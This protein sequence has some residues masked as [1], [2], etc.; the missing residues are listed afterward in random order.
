MNWR[1]IGACTLAFAS[2]QF[3]PALG[4]TDIQSQRVQ[5]AR[6]ASSATVKGTIKGYAIRDYVVGARAGQT[7]TVKL[8]TPNT[9]NYFNVTPAGSDTAIFVGSTS[10]NSF[11]GTLPVSGDYTIRVYLMR[12]A[13]RRNETANYALAIGVTG[14]PAAVAPKPSVDAV[15]PGTQ[16]HAVTSIPCKAAP[17]QPTRQCKAGVIRSPGGEA[18]VRITLPGGSERNIYFNNGNASSSDARTPKFSVTRDGDTSIVT[19]GAG[20]RYEIPD[21]LVTGG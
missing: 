13:A 5:F 15:V 19:V 10:G 21:M 11:R 2:V 4:Q 14:R 18:T 16:F 1:L 7:M 12:S 9:A 6:G 20:E 3:S 8:T 17:G